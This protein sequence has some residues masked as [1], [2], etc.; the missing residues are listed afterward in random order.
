[1]N[2]LLSVLSVI[3]VAHTTHH[4]PVLWSRSGIWW[5]VWGSLIG[6]ISDEIHNKIQALLSTVPHFVYTQTQSV[7]SCWSRGADNQWSTELDCEFVITTGILWLH[8]TCWWLPVCPCILFGMCLTILLEIIEHITAIVLLVCSTVS[9]DISAYSLYMAFLFVLTKNKTL[10]ERDGV[11]F[12]EDM[13][14]VR[15]F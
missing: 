3:L 13:K 6:F 15:S 1:M 9:S 5:I 2:E 4:T 12:S 14:E 10:N 8:L 7:H 11:T